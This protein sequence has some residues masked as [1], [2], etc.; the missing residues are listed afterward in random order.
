MDGYN[1]T[2]DTISI[3]QFTEYLKM[4]ITP[5]EGLVIPNVTIPSHL[6][7]KKRIT[8]ADDTIILNIRHLFNSLSGDNVEKIRE[9]LRETIMTKTSGEQMLNDVAKEILSNFLISDK[10][11]SSYMHLL[12]AVS[13]AC[14]EIDNGARTPTIAKYFIDECKYKIFDFISEK[15]VREL[16]SMDIDDEDEL[17]IYNRKRESIINLISTLCHLYD[18][19]NDNKKIKVTA[20]NLYPLIDKIINI[21]NDIRSK[22]KKL[23]DLYNG[24]DCEN[25]QEYEILARMANLYAEQLYTFISKRAI[26]FINDKTIIRNDNMKSLVEKFRNQIVPTLTEAYLIAKC[27]LIKYK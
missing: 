18:Q 3:Q 12:N 10:N 25:E 26:E 19:R 6:M 5:I 11:I 22:M 15:F 17:D 1:Y 27:D 14:L 21:Y 8:Q 20:S 23:G 2:P 13:N 16:A 24:E 7:N 9:L 4:D